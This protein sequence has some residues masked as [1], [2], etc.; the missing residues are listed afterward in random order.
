M[1]SC[2]APRRCFILSLCL[3]SLSHYVFTRAC[4]PQT[5]TV[6]DFGY[7]MRLMGTVTTRL[8]GSGEGHPA[9]IYERTADK[10]LIS[11]LTNPPF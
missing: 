7:H 5:S 6:R 3:H 2:L 8:A 11:Q 1:C 10:V 9:Y 4:P